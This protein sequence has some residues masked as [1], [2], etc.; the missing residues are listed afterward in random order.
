MCCLIFY[1]ICF[2]IQELRAGAPRAMPKEKPAAVN[3]LHKNG[4]YSLKQNKGLSF[5]PVNKMNIYLSS[6]VFHD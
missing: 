6:H 4:K 3:F 2:Q 5:L 1:V